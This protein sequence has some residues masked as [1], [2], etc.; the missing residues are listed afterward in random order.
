[1]AFTTLYLKNNASPQANKP[2]GFLGAWGTVAGSGQ[3]DQSLEAANGTASVN[4]T[5]NTTGAHTAKDYG[6]GTFHTP[7]LAAQTIAAGNWTIGLTGQ[8]GLAGSGRSWTPRMSL[9]LVDGSNGTLRSTIFAI[10]NIGA[11]ARTATALRTGYDTAIAGSAAT[12]TA[13]DYLVLEIGLSIVSTGDGTPR[14]LTMRF[15]NSTAITSDN[16]ANTTPMAFLTAPASVLEAT[17]VLTIVA[18]A[19]DAS[20]TI[21]SGT[22]VFRDQYIV[23]TALD[24][25]NTPGGGTVVVLAN[26]FVLATALDASGTPGDPTVATVIEATALDASSTPG[27]GIVTQPVAP[28]ALDASS[29]PGNATVQPGNVNVQA[30]ALDASGG[31]GSPGVL[32]GGVNIIALAKDTDEAVGLALILGGAPSSGSTT[33]GYRQPRG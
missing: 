12:V 25:S 10:G 2:A 15:A 20:V 9:Y 31:Q 24:A 17:D 32:P 4:F 1:M 30:S 11:T 18:N 7:A 8:Y 28:S 29:T 5:V 3:R 16:V 21:G 14:T 33:V 27:D 26:Q 23:T 13:G 19:L 22:V 6:I